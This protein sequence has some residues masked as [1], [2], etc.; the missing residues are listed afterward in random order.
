MDI[1]YPRG[2]RRYVTCFPVKLHNS[3]TIGKCQSR[4]CDDLRRPKKG[5]PLRHF[6]ELKTPTRNSKRAWCGWQW[7]LHMFMVRVRTPVRARFNWKPFFTKIPVP[8]D[9]CIAVRPFL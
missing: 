2:V 6:N 1:E 4:Y 9:R 3:R 7:Y 5:R 8:N